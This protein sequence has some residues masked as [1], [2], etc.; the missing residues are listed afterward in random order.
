M[1]RLLARSLAMTMA[2]FRFEFRLAGP[3]LMFYLPRTFQPDEN[4]FL[5]EGRIKAR[6][7][8]RDRGIGPSLEIQQFVVAMRCNGKLTSYYKRRASHGNME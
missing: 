7:W 6:Q 3:G 2:I 1:C 4:P 8:M 5:I